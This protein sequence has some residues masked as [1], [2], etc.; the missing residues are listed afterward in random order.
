MKTDQISGYGIRVF[1]WKKTGR[2]SEIWVIS[3]QIPHKLT[4]FVLKFEILEISSW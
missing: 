3:L 1:K 4:V 2:N